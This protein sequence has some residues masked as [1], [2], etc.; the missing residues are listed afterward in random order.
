MHDL[1]T[2]EITGLVRIHMTAC[3]VEDA[4][5]ELER[6]CTDGELEEL[7]RTAE[8]LKGLFNAVVE[9]CGDEDRQV[10]IRN[11]AA[12]L[13]V[14]VGYADTPQ[15]GKYLVDHDDLEF[16]IDHMLNYCDM[17]CPCVVMDEETGERSIIK[18]AVKGCEVRKLY[19]RIGV[20]EGAS[21]EC[22]YS[23]YLAGRHE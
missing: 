2:R 1:S 17:D 14:K 13:K 22:P 15:Q 7:S 18:Q 9:R 21:P 4:V 6:V 19:K 3:S 5:K 16:L 23:M 8:G 20:A 11:R 10:M 12:S